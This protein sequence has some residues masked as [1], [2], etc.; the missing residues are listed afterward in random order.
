MSRSPEEIRAEHDRNYDAEIPR[1]QSDWETWM[2]DFGRDAIF[3][4]TFWLRDEGK[5]STYCGEYKIW[6]AIE[7]PDKQLLI[8]WRPVEWDGLFNSV[9][10]HLL[11]D[12]QIAYYPPEKE[13]E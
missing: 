10:Y 7:L 5:W 11:R 9:E 8:G 6:Q 2:R 12:C 13:D 3:R 1:M 4:V